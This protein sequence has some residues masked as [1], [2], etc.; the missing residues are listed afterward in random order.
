MKKPTV[1]ILTN[2]P[3]DGTSFSGGVETATAGLLEGLAAYAT[4]FDFHVMAL[5]KDIKH[6]IAEVRCG[7]TFHFLSIPSAW[8]ARP[9]VIPN[10]VNARAALKNLQAD[11]IHCQD[12]MSLALGAMSVQT[13]RKLFTVH[14]IKSVESHLW[15]GPE[16][17]SHQMDAVL[18]RWVRRHFDEVI[19][20]SPYVDQF[21]P[22][23]VRKHHIPNPVR[24]IF[25]EH[26]RV[27]TDA[28][29]ILFVGTC[30]RLKRPMDLLRAFAEVKVHVTD[31]TL[32]FAGPHEDRRYVE[33][34]KRVIAQE[35][36]RDVRFVG[37][38]TPEQ[39][40][41][42]MRA[43]TVLVLP[44]A[45]ENSPMVV[46]E[47]MAIGLP[48]IASRVG[49]VPYMI[50]DGVEGLLFHCGNIPDLVRH[51]L[52]V[53]EHEALRQQLTGNARRK[54]VAMFSPDAVG[55]ATVSVYRI[56]LER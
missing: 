12:N 46:A 33:E 49:G 11:I 27:E 30:T 20:I 4:E 42:L 34:M 36:I 39:I 47:A 8:Y 7:M 21:L 6:H 37:A 45:Q 2:Y 9:H 51:L 53:L 25:L 28:L 13:S 14:G 50:Q 10:V 24:R 5:S 56:L 44:S 31:A 43:S 38:Q 16:Y 17:W 35:Q 18:E 3:Y 54:A 15:E 41:D 29:H 52:R 48:V 55:A 1:V 32:T 23:H 40:A 22:A 19:T 26:P